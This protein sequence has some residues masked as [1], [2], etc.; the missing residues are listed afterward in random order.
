LATAA[1]NVVYDRDKVAKGFARSRT[2]GQN[3]A[4][5]F[6]CD[7]N[8]VFLV[9]VETK[10]CPHPPRCFSGLKNLAAFLMKHISVRKVFDGA[11][12][13]EVGIEVH[14]GGR[15]KLLSSIFAVHKVLYI[16]CSEPRE[17]SAE[18]LVVTRYVLSKLK[19]VQG[20]SPLAT[21]RTA[22]LSFT[23]QRPQSVIAISAQL[24][25]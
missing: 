21:Q 23:P 19:N 5:A 18:S 20:L 16:R 15:P 25:H 12:G 17:A 6:L 2:C 8:G 11:T 14:Q 10:R 24:N 1:K 22:C 4:F 9:F 3:I 13:N 7:A